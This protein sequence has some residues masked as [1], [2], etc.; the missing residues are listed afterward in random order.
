[1]SRILLVDDSPH[2]QRMGERILS[3]EGFEVVTVSNAD[4]ALIRLDDVAP[5]VVLADTVMPGRTGYDICHFLKMS[6]RHRHVKVILT[7]G[8]LEPL[9]EEQ[10]KRVEADATLKKPFE[11]SALI[12]AVRPLAAAAAALRATPGAASETAVQGARQGPAVPFVAV[13]DA[14]QVRAA[15]TVA[16]DASMAK[17]VDEIASRVLAALNSG[18]VKSGKPEPHAGEPH[19]TAVRREGAPAA[20]PVV[21]LAPPEPL[22]PVAWQP[23]P[24]QPGAQRIEPVR[25]VTPLRLRSGSVLG[26]EIDRPAPEPLEPGPE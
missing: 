25:R 12:A 3:E 20:S 4:S 9:D 19:A 11:A 10:A 17:M 16:L 18:T 21:K 14:E 5:D 6:P 2:A 13:V 8:V 24:P 22:R 7:A 26:L 1:M 15:V 23:G